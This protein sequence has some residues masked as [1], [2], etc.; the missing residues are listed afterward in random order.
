MQR[1]KASAAPTTSTRQRKALHWPHWVV[2][3]ASVG[4]TLVAWNVARTEHNAKIALRFDREAR[5]VVSLVEEG[6]RQYEHA[7]WGGV[8]FFDSMGGDVDLDQWRT[9]A[10][11]LRIEVRHPGINGI[12]VIDQVD[13]SDRDAYIA[14]QRET[15]PDFQI[16]REHERDV[17]FPIRFIEPVEINAAAVGLDIAH[18]TNRFTATIRARD[19]GTAQITGPIVLVQDSGRTPGFLFH[20]PRYRERHPS[21]A[22]VRVESFEGTIYAPFVVRRLMD[23]VLASD[24][25]PVGFRLTDD[26][27]T[28]YDELQVGI[29]DFD[30]T[31]SHTTEISVPLYG[32]MWVFEIWS[33]ESFAAANFSAQPTMILIGGIVIDV[34]LVTLF[35]ML[36]RANRRANALADAATKELTERNAELEQF[37]YSASH[38]LKSPLLT[39][40]GF[41]GFLSEDIVAGDFDRAE[42]FTERIAAGATRMHRSIEDLLELSR[43]GRVNES[44]RLIDA[45]SLARDIVEELSPL[46][47]DARAVVHVDPDIPTITGD[48]H[49]VRQVLEN[50]IN[51]ALKYGRPTEGL[52]QINIGGA[53][54]GDSVQLFVEDNGPGVDP[55]YRDRIF[56]LF[57]RVKQSGDGTGVGLAIVKRVAEVHGG[58]AWTEPAP[59]GG[60]R[61]IVSFPKSN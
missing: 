28:L 49:R 11:S 18:E 40:Q 54:D 13:P 61:F 31:P 3:F 10:E 21:D 16:R 47:A 20:A 26:G 55:A 41:I 14:T 51:N 17:L 56:E 15:Q 60:A 36:T 9:Y 35:A 23:G 1:P 52:P 53:A 2:V 57:T 6:L 33:S 4:L 50:L 43:V 58:R 48:L 19:T 32:R 45:S 7:L 29:P 24:R 46:I 34:L 42:E 22:D 44:N 12:G 30:S 38:D 8:A 37:V 5:Q 59:G 39:I 27:E 25:R